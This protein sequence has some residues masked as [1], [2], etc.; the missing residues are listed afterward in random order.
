MLYSVKFCEKNENTRKRGREWS[1][2]VIMP[3]LV[4]YQLNQIYKFTQVDKIGKA[5]ST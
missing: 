4:N 1:I 2:F 5:V 3:M